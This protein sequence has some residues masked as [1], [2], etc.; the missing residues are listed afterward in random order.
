MLWEFSHKPFVVRSSIQTDARG[1]GDSNVHTYLRD[2]VDTF[3]Q[4][5][6]HL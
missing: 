5:F 4:L 3:E 1:K 2:Y 6:S